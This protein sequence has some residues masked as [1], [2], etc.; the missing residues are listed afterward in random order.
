MSRQQV[1]Q[2]VPHVL[3]AA[4]ERERRF[5]AIG[6]PAHTQRHAVVHVYFF[7]IHSCLL[8]AYNYISLE[9]NII[10]VV[11]IRRETNFLYSP[12]LSVRRI[13]SFT[14]SANVA[15]GFLRSRGHSSTIAAV[16]GDSIAS[17]S[18]K[19]PQSE[20]RTAQH[21]AT[22]LERQAPLAHA[23]RPTFFPLAAGSHARIYAHA[24]IHTYTHAHIHTH[25]HTRDRCTT[26]QY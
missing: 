20:K 13:A 6:R 11:S 8:S 12:S 15:R 7:N 22:N 9:K 19:Q 1:N 17:Y 3:I 23:L 16:T 14:S 24:H 5:G 26:P 25:T 21:A 18:W 10:L 4:V 2:I